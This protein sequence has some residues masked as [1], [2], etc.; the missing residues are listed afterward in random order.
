MRFGGLLCIDSLDV[1]IKQ[2]E[3]LGMIGPK[4]AG[5]TTVF[6]IVTGVYEPT[7]GKIILNGND[8]TGIKTY[9]IAEKGISRTFQ[10]IRLFSSL[11]VRDNVRVSFGLRNKHKFFSSIVETKSFFA[12]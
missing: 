12:V 1:Y 9:Q 6:N 2:N 3:L 11:S 5:K 10:N 4:G 8:I 7:E